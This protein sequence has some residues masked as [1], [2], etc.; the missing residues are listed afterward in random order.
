MKTIAAK[1]ASVRQEQDGADDDVHRLGEQAQRH[2]R[3]GGALL[4]D[5][6]RGEQC[7]A[8]GAEA[9]DLGRVPR[10]L[11]P[12]PRG[13]EQDAG[14]R[15]G[16]QRGAGDVDAHLRALERDVQRRDDQ[17]QRGGADRQVDVEDPAPRQ[18]VG[19]DAA[20][21][22]S[23]D[24]GHDEDHL[25]VALVAAALA[26]RDDIAD[27]RHGQ[28]HEASGARA[29]Q[30]AEGDELA[31]AAGRAAQRRA[32]EEDEDRRDEQRLAAEEVAGSTPQRH[33]DRRAEQVG[34]DD[35]RQLVDAAEVADDRGQRGGDD[36]L[37]EGGEEHREQQA[38]EG[39]DELAA[40]QGG[41]RLGSGGVGG[42]RAH[43]KE[44]SN[45][46]LLYQRLLESL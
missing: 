6:E 27:D 37:V 36:G 46:K 38:R 44:C 34:G 1:N 10:V 8:G 32:G 2:D 29:L 40:A 9:E 21:Q 19:E 14:Q 25:D 23:R 31:E 30:R 20:E 5:D 11:A 43:G 16:E 41:R 22:R 18:V 33:R 45:P 4:L 12:A 35:P 26:R 7:D 3:L 39:H 42:G 15:A 17:A 24:A 13:D 28:G